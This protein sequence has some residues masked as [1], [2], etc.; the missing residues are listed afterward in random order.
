MSRFNRTMRWSSLMN[1]AI[2][3]I[4]P[5]DCCQKNQIAHN[6]HI[7]SILSDWL[8]VLNLNNF[9]Y[10]NFFINLVYK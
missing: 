4:G 7:L 10:P 1:L 9:C 5:Y 2:I 8:V 6:F 3:T